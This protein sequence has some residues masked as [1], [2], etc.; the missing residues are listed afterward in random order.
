[1]TGARATAA[2]MPSPVGEEDRFAHARAKGAPQLRIDQ[3]AP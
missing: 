1:V 3:G 2:R